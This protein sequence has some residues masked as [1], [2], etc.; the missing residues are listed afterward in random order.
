MHC[1]NEIGDRATLQSQSPLKKQNQNTPI[2]RTESHFTGGD[3]KLTGVSKEKQILL[4]EV[5]ASH[6]EP[7]QWKL[8]LFAEFEGKQDQMLRCGYVVWIHHSESNSII[9]ALRRTKGVSKY[10]FSSLH[11]DTWIATANLELVSLRSAQSENFNEFSGNTF[12][13]FV[14]E[15]ENQQEGGYLQFARAYRLKHISSG[16]YLTVTNNNHNKEEEISD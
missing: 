2:H 11:L 10:N 6:E 8:N 7:V 1:S 3:K 13:M 14:I 9:S 5:N 12:G 15:G 4:R 16:C